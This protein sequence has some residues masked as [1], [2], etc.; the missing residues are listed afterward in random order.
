MA[1]FITLL[2]FTQKG[3]ENIKD[4]P[5]RLDQAK[6]M[7]SSKGAEIKEFYLVM[8]QYDAVVITEEPDD[9]TAAGIRL[10]VAALGYVSTKT[11][12]AF[13]EEEYRDIVNELP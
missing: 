8:G 2:N 3:V 6:K 1:T 9:S 7:F 11:M 13:T 10:A 4:G 12:R 5:T